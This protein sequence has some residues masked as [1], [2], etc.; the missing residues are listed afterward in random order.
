MPGF[1]VPHLDVARCSVDV[2]PA[3]GQ[4]LSP[5]QAGTG[6]ELNK[7][8]TELGRRLFELGKDPL[9]FL[10]NEEVDIANRCLL[11]K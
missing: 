11:G 5:A 4:G 6:Q 3:K 8:Q 9:Q 1:A 2:A 7:R 10:G